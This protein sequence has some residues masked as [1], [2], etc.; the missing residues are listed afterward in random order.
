MAKWTTERTLQPENS[1]CFDEIANHRALKR[2]RF[3]V[4]IIEHGDLVQCTHRVD[5]WQESILRHSYVDQI[6]RKLRQSR[7]A[8]DLL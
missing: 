5:I 3:N 1:I 7:Q 6:E 2:I 8:G 4:V